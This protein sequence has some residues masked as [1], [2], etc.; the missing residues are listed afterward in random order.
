M[1]TINELLEVITGTQRRYTVDGDIVFVFRPPHDFTPQCF[2]MLRDAIV[3]VDRKFPW[4]D[5]N[6]HDGTEVSDIRYLG[7]AHVVIHNFNP[8]EQHVWFWIV[9]HYDSMRKSQLY[10]YEKYLAKLAEELNKKRFFRSDS[11]RSVFRVVSSTSF[12]STQWSQS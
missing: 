11:V 5:T 9:P 12:D 10:A 7:D 3:F 6:D 4:K 1:R 8:Q 2:E